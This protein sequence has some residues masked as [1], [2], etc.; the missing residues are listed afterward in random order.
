MKVRG[1][2]PGVESAHFHLGLFSPR[3][4]GQQGLGR[5]VIT[6]EESQILL[7]PQARQSLESPASS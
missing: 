4:Q 5:K 2:Y 7:I 6:L 1:S 3:S